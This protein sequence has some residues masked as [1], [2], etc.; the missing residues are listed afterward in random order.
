ME[1][2]KR[3]IYAKFNFS[4]VEEQGQVSAVWHIHSCILSSRRKQ[5]IQLQHSSEPR[6]TGSYES[7]SIPITIAIAIASRGVC[8]ESWARCGLIGRHWRSDSSDHW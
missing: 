5:Y 4:R 2:R 1:S 7:A 6:L 3:G 8:W